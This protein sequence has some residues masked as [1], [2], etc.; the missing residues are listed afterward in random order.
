MPVLISIDKWL[1]VFPLMALALIHVAAPLLP[2]LVIRTNSHGADRKHVAEQKRGVT[3]SYKTEES[4][5]HY[6]KITLFVVLLGII[7]GLGSH[8]ID[9]VIV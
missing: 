8:G 3:T 1:G 9:T 2:F 4:Y 7:T 5:K 6:H